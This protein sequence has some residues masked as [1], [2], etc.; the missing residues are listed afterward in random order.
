LTVKNGDQQVSHATASL[1]HSLFENGQSSFSVE[2]GGVS[3]LF[4]VGVDVSLRD[5]ESFMGPLFE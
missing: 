2:L 3:V 1:R 5:F 4:E